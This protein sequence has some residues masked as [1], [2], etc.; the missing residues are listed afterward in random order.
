M[1]TSPPDATG[2]PAVVSV[3]G[4]PGDLATISATL[5]LYVTDHVDGET[6]FFGHLCAATQRWAEAVTLW[7]AYRARLQDDGTVDV[8]L[9]ALRRQ[10]PMQKAVQALEPGGCAQPK[11]AVRP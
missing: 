4:W 6:S 7:A 11:N 8:P 3:G 10:E 5:T 1:P 2:L 9:D